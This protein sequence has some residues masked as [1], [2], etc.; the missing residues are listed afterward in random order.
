[1]DHAN[2][3]R[4]AEFD[5]RLTDHLP[6][7]KKVARRQVRNMQERDDLVQDVF[8]HALAKWRQFRPDGSFY[9]WI[10]FMVRM[11]ASEKRRKVIRQGRHLRQVE[12]EDILAGLSTPARQ[13]EEIDV[14]EVYNLIPAGRNGDILRRRIMG[15]TLAEI[16][17]DYG[18]G[19]E[20]VRQIEWDQREAL[21][22][23]LGMSSAAVAA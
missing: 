21:R 18:I 6:L 13:I 2:D 20:R 11:I 12:G 23:A 22:A 9:M 7:I 14:M 19:R 3:N 8:A 16:G 17:S 1:M 5:R 15:D 4:P 10:T